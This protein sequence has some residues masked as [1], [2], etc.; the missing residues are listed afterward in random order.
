MTN[1]MACKP[2]KTI[3]SNGTREKLFSKIEEERNKNY[4]NY[5]TRETEKSLDL[6]AKCFIGLCKNRL[7]LY[8]KNLKDFSD[9]DITELMKIM[10]ETSIRYKKKNLIIKLSL[11]II[12]WTSLAVQYLNIKLN[13]IQPNLLCYVKIYN[14][15]K[16]YGVEKEKIIES[17]KKEIQLS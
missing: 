4:K 10:L 17:I 1:E 2:S 7:K 14:M 5:I 13:I 6:F 11:P 8:K 3:I 15:L 16:K 9:E 12:G